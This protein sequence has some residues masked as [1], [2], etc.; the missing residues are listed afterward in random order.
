M[1]MVHI[2]TPPVQI[3][4]GTNWASIAAG[5]YHTIALKSDGTLWAWGNNSNGG[6]GMAQIPIKTPLC[7]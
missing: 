7:R 6:L 4:T 2:K 5:G 1:A 3:G